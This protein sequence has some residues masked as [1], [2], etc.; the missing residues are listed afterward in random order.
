MQSIFQS[1]GVCPRPESHCGEQTTIQ[2]GKCHVDFGPDVTMEAQSFDLTGQTPIPRR[3]EANA[4]SFC[5]EQTVYRDGKCHVKF[6]PEE[7]FSFPHG[8]TS[9][10]LTYDLTDNDYFDSIPRRIIVTNSGTDEGPCGDGTIYRDGKCRV[11]WANESI[12]ESMYRAGASFPELLSNEQVHEICAR[13]IAEESVRC[14]TA[15]FQSTMETLATQKVVDEFAFLFTQMALHKKRNERYFPCF[16]AA[17]KG[18]MLDEIYEHD[19]LQQKMDVLDE[20]KTNGLDSRLF[21][22]N[23]IYENCARDR[24][25]ELWHS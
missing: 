8:F 7:N 11:D 10:Q 17:A 15:N 18:Y 16:Y 20:L 3:I 14:H 25:G 9:Y 6:G 2:D 4:A 24:K 19:T 1:L 21:K 22:E 13:P 23:H 5:G 12:W